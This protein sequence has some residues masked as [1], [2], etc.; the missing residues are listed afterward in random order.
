MRRRRTRKSYRK[1]A[2]WYPLSFPD[3][4]EK[5]VFFLKILVEHF[6]LN[7]QYKVTCDKGELNANP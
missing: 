4:D 5:T 1:S 2:S 6:S 7:T 3:N